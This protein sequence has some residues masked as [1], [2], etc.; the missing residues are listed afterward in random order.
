MKENADSNRHLIRDFVSI[1]HFDIV[2]PNFE[3]RVWSYEP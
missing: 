3:G 1:Y 2:A